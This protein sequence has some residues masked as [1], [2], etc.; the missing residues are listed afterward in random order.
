VKWAAALTVAAGLAALPLPALAFHPQVG[1]A[2][3]A[4][5]RGEYDAALELVRRVADGT[6]L[7]LR[8]LA[9]L[10]LVR[11]IAHAGRGEGE[12]LA[13]AALAFVALGAP[14]PTD[15][16]PAAVVAAIEEARLARPDPPRVEVVARAV[17]EGLRLTVEVDDDAAVIRAVKLAYR[18]DDD[19]WQST[20]D[21]SVLVRSLPGARVS[22]HA[23]ATGDGGA[24]VA[25]F[26]S[27][28]NPRTASM[29]SAEGDVI[30]GLGAM[31][32]APTPR[33]RQ[34]RSVLWVTTGIA[35][36]VIAVI[37]AIAVS[38]ALSDQSTRFD[39]PVVSW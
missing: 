34:S 20:T 33:A 25:T 27:A 29:P 30:G 23:R 14:L 26:G 12:L 2:R 16:L 9:E 17:P 3:A 38:G 22:F 28:S 39:A 7:G 4:A 1:A 24:T 31:P 8:D 11:A 13:A 35:V 18:V 36:G 10:Y 5:L 32:V 15:G 6:D 37:V 21:A 19:P